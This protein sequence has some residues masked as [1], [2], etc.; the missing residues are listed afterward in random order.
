MPAAGLATSLIFSGVTRLS[1]PSARYAVALGT[2]CGLGIGL[3][4][5]G[6]RYYSG[7]SIKVPSIMIENQAINED[8][9]EG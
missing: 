9:R 6:Y 1:L 8:C 3:L 5:D 7:R 4:Q 2:G